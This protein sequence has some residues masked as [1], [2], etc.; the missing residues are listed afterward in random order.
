MKNYLFN[1]T[2]EEKR[3]ILEM[4]SSE[5]KLINE[6]EILDDVLDKLKNHGFDS[7]DFYEKS[8][9]DNYGKYMSSGKNPNRY[10]SPEK[11]W[12]FKGLMDLRKQLENIK[13]DLE[14]RD[15]KSNSCPLK[16]PEADVHTVYD[17]DVKNSDEYVATFDGKLIVDYNDN[18][19]RRD[20]DG[21]RADGHNLSEYDKI[22]CYKTIEE[23]SKKFPIWCYKTFQYY[24]PKLFT[25]S[26]GPNK[27]TDYP[28]WWWKLQDFETPV[29]PYRQDDIDQEQLRNRSKKMFSEYVKT[30]RCGC[31]EVYKKK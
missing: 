26:E 20:S 17:E 10:S 1:I 14:H 19:Y 3:R 12:Q 30:S 11:G 24:D 6:D 2:R 8:V 22:A 5:K 21:N 27:S 7:L 9:L 25:N 31:L 29:S 18:Q 16:N 15:K 4:H 13:P 28:D 23:F